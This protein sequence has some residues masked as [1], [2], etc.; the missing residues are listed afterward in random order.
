MCKVR[1]RDLAH[2]AEDKQCAQVKRQSPAR[3]LRLHRGLSIGCIS[4]GGWRRRTVF[5]TSSRSRSRSCSVVGC[6]LRRVA[7]VWPL[8][9]EWVEGLTRRTTSSIGSGRAAGCVAWGTAVSIEWIEA[10]RGTRVVLALG[11]VS[12]EIVVRAGVGIG[13]G[14]ASSRGIGVG[15]DWTVA[16]RRCDRGS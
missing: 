5:R 15:S 11:V 2:K 1:Y 7:P 12:R 8:T 16:G 14:I 3:L 10:V 13:S 6:L 4:G 9:I